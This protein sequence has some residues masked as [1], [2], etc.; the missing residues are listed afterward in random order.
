[1][2]KH[3]DTHAARQAAQQTAGK[4]SSDAL[5]R[6]FT[7]WQRLVMAVAALLVGI[8]AAIGVWQYMAGKSVYYIDDGNYQAIFL[9]S[10]QVYFG[11]LQVLH[12]A[13][14]RLT[15]VYYPRSQ[16]SA[17]LQGEANAETASGQ[18]SPQLMKFGGELLGPQD[19]IVFPATQVQY[20]VNLKADS[21]VSQ[22]IN[23][24]RTK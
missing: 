5:R 7:W 20:W 22:A 18:A 4:T 10:G 17:S 3:P 24:Y 11:K 21:K 15:D 2:G 6:P 12:D 19:E 9:A 1:M 16:N 14:Y 23:T 13:S 8:A